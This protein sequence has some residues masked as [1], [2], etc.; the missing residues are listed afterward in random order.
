M[1]AE[2][3]LGFITVILIVIVIAIAWI[4]DD[5]ENKRVEA[6]LMEHPECVVATYPRACLKYTL[7]LERLQNEQR[8]N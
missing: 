3:I 1:D 8:R 6:M 7:K 2:E 4:F 5:K